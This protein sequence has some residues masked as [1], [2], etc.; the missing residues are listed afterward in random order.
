MRIYLA[1][2]WR[3]KLDFHPIRSK[4]L[5]LGHIVTSGWLD[6]SA[7]GDHAIIAAERDFHDIDRADTLILWHELKL[8]IESLYGGMF[9]EVGYA[10]AK[11]KQVWAVLE[12]KPTCIFL[13]LP[14]VQCFQD[15]ESCFE[16][17]GQIVHET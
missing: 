2:R 10:L 5:A 13:S 1:G 16:S 11:G 7:A 17:L 6:E 4:I 14:S 8:P 3:K 15:W 12:T 9:V